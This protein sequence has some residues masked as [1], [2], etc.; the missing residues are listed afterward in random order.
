MEA[1]VHFMQSRNAVTP[2]SLIL[3]DIRMQF[4]TNSTYKIY[5]EIDIRV[6]E[7]SVR[8]YFHNI[9]RLS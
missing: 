6:H 1:D 8:V 3:L 5:F 7:M 4:Q 9:V 2:A